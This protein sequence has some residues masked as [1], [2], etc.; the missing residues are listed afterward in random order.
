MDQSFL[1]TEFD[2]LLSKGLVLYD[3]KQTLVRQQ[4]GGLTVRYSNFAFLGFSFPH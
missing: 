3:D 4:D 2:R 1:I